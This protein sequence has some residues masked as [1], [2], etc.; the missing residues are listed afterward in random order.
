MMEKQKESTTTR[1][2]EELSSRISDILERKL[3]HNGKVADA[4]QDSL[5]SCSVFMR[6]QDEEGGG[7]F[8]SRATPENLKRNELTAIREVE[9][10]DDDALK[11]LPPARI[12]SMSVF[13]CYL[14]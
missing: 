4:Q 1:E 7:L 5:L 11:I 14:K 10:N 12:L 2:S 6:D 13:V 3:R 9:S 8:D